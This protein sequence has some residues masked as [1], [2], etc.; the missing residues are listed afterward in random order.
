MRPHRSRAASPPMAYRD[1]RPRLGASIG[2]APPATARSTR[3]DDDPPTPVDPTRPSRR[4]SMA[5]PVTDQLL[6]EIQ[7]LIRDREREGVRGLA[8][9]VGPS[10]WA[11]LVPR[12]DPEE[13]AVLIRWL[14]D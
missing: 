13:V 5:N 10:D 14:P 4:P 1:I 9:R 7:E 6:G 2:T 8:E 3:P 11:E 12:L